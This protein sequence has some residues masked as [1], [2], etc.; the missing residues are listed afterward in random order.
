[1]SQSH[2]VELLVMVQQHNFSSVDAFNPTVI[3]DLMF[4]DAWERGHARNLSAFFR[5]RQI[6][7]ANR[8]CRECGGVSA[9]PI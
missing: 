1:M 6:R 8:D 9:K 4:F 5:A 7:R 2:T 3:E